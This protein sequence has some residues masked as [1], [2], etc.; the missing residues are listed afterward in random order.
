MVDAAGF[1]RDRPTLSINQLD[2]QTHK[3][4][5]TD[6]KGAAD[7]GLIAVINHWHRLSRDTKLAILELAGGGL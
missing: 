5:H 6:G 7:I 3:Q 4:S 1:E 2:R